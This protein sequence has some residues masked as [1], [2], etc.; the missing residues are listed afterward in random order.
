MLANWMSAA[1]SADKTFA[2]GE[3]ALRADLEEAMSTV[4]IATDTLSDGLD[5]LG[6]PETPSGAEV[7]RVVDELSADISARV[8][9][10]DQALDESADEPPFPLFRAMGIVGTELVGAAGD[11]VRTN[12]E[13]SQL[14]PELAR[15]L[16][17]SAACTD[18]KEEL[19]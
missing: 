8:R 18:L 7:E 16:D 11:I 13:I 6:P 15:A 12:V 4:D 19:T 5:L 17:D 10:A 3:V 2:S 9:R 14:D 1:K